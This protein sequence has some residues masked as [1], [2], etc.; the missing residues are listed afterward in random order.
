[1]QRIKVVSE[2][3]SQMGLGHLGVGVQ[4]RVGFTGVGIMVGP[5]KF[6]RGQDVCPVK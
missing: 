3:S 2:I 6:P 4:V 5:L 1:M